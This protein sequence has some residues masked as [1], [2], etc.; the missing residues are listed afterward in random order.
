LPP[1]GIASYDIRLIDPNIKYFPN[2]KLKKTSIHQIKKAIPI[3][4]AFLK[5]LVVLFWRTSLEINL[6]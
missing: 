6:F 1:I 4:T 5:K 2:K 3:R